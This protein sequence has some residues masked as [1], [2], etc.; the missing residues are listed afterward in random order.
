MIYPILCFHSIAEALYIWFLLSFSVFIYNMPFV[1]FIA[2]ICD[3]FF[4]VIAFMHYIRVSLF[5]Q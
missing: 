1:I 5:K 3:E 4:L 2:I